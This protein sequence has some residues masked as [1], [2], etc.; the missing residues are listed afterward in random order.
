MDKP[1][2][3]TGEFQDIFDYAL[4]AIRKQ[5]KPSA[6]LKK[7]GIDGR[8]VVHCLYGVPGGPRCAIGH[9]LP[10]TVPVALLDQIESKTAASAVPMAFEREFPVE[11]AGNARFL[12]ALQQCHDSAARGEGPTVYTALNSLT[13]PKIV[14]VKEFRSE[15]ERNMQGLARRYSLEYTAP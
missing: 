13:Q 9:M 1:N 5:G 7:Q 6:V 14:G 4:Q 11:S 2:L 12:D 15:F 10:D 8:K 3:L